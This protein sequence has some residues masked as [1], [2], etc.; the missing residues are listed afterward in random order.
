M[1]IYVEE[2][3]VRAVPGGV[4]YA[5]TA[6]NYAASLYP[7]AMARQKGYDQILWTDAHEHKYLQEIGTMNLVIVIGDKAITPDLKSGT[8]LAGVTRNS[9][10]TLLQEAGLAVEE[11]P[12]SIDEVIDAY[13]S[14]NLR[15]VFGTG[16]AA[17]ISPIKELRY[18]DFVM[19]F[20]TEKWEVSPKI[21]RWLDDIH[22]GEREDKYEWMVKV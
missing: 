8:I 22:E 19:T 7:A 17:T 1:R 15:E 16:T 12:I 9:V 4:G 13:K 20:E 5:K 18:K 2:H 3:Y 21:K 14:G 10:L 6:G 11:R